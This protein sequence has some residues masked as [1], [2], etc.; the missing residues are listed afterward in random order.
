[1]EWLQ[2]GWATVR[3]VCAR[4][5]GG[6]EWERKKECG[7]LSTLDDA[8]IAGIILTYW[9]FRQLTL[10][11]IVKLIQVI[12]KKL[13]WFSLVVLCRARLFLKKPVNNGHYIFPQQNI[14]LIR[15]FIK[16]HQPRYQDDFNDGTFGRGA[17]LEYILRLGSSFDALPKIT[18]LSSNRIDEAFIKI[19][20]LIRVRSILN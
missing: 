13:N 4:A 17:T 8:F 14:P 2:S 16:I 7:R 18:M 19:R 12:P 6:R 5:R 9:P 11:P 20:R 3:D 10:V 15:G 1:M